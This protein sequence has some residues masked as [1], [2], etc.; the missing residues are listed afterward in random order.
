MN[1]E[2][3]G[4]LLDRLIEDPE[5]RTEILQE[6]DID[7]EEQNELASLL[8]ASD[9][10]WLSAHGA[11]PLDQDPVAAMLG[12]V[13]DPHMT[14]DSK[15]LA[16]HRK[17][18]RLTVSDVAARLSER[19]WNVQAGDVFRWE[20]RSAPDVPPAMI[21]AI[22]GVLATSPELISVRQ[23][24]AEDQF[25]AVRNTARFQNLVSRWMTALDLSRSMAVAALEGRMVATVHRGEEPDSEQL[26]AALD[27]LVEAVEQ[28]RGTDTA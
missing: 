22:A 7:T 26:L 18:A 23:A 24:A 14:L 25:A 6:V 13:A 8:K 10:V 4:R 20:S 2:D 9:A 28:S 5:H 21:Q 16:R 19:G 3:Y 15:A 11:P 17:R 1:E 27:V 12:L